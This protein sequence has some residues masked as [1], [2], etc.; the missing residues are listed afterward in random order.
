M[1]KIKCLSTNG[2]KKSKIKGEITNGTNIANVTKKSTKKSKI[3]SWMA[4]LKQGA[5]GGQG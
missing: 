1:V 3:K 2:T 5:S 4:A